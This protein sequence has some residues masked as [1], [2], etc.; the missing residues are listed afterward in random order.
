M[1]V[2]KTTTKK[3]TPSSKRFLK[4]EIPVVKDPTVETKII[5]VEPT[6]F[7]K[8]FEKPKAKKI[9]KKK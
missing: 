9:S 5:P 8:E 1:S 4:Q 3:T 2:R 7:H 6:V